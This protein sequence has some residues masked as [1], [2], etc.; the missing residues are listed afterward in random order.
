MLFFP[1]FSFFSNGAEKDDGQG[2]ACLLVS[3]RIDDKMD[4]SL[5]KTLIHLVMRQDIL[6]SNGKNSAITSLCGN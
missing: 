5:K 6:K 1:F 4:L 2:N 3:L